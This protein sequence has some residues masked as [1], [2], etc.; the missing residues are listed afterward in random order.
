VSSDS[1]NIPNTGINTKGT[2]EEFLSGH[3]SDFP[4][5]GCNKMLHFDPDDELEGDETWVSEGFDKVYCVDCWDKDK[6][7]PR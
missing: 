1:I 4:C 5:S 7:R 2:L 6:G 3:L